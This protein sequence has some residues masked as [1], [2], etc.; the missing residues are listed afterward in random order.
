MNESSA[1]S[2]TYIYIT[3][4]GGYNVELLGLPP[5]KAVNIVKRRLAECHAVMAGSKVVKYGT[6]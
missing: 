1:G 5:L 2:L 4:I 3:W 6:K